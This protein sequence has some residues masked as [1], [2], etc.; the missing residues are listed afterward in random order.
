M[1]GSGDSLRRAEAGTDAA[2]ESPEGD[3]AVSERLGPHAEGIGCPVR[4]LPCFCA[5]DLPSGNA[6]IGAESEPGNKSFFSGELRRIETD[7]RDDRLY[8]EDI[9]AGYLGEVYAAYPVELGAK[10]D[11]GLISDRLLPLFFLLRKG[12]LSRIDLPLNRVQIAFHLPVAGF[13]LP[14]IE[15][16]ELDC[17]F[18]GEEVLG[19]VVSLKSLGDNFGGIL[20][21][22]LSHKGKFLGVPFSGYDCPD[23]V[24]AGDAGHVCEYLMEVKIH[25]SEGFLHVLDMVRGV[26]DKVRPVPP[27][28]PQDAYL[29]VG[30][31]GAG[32]E[33]IG[34]EALEP[35]AV[36][37]VA[38]SSGHV[39]HM[40]GIHELYLESVLFEDLEGRDPVDP[41]RLHGDRSDSAFFQPPRHSVEVGREAAEGPYR[42]LVPV[43]RHSH[44]MFFRTDVDAR[45]I[46]VDDRERTRPSGARPSFFS[47]TVS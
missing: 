17:L 12:I 28:R 16:V 29:I 15:V 24:H 32:E 46:I 23:D 19:P 5:L 27:V 8:G 39:L 47:R 45:S 3:I 21:S 44:P 41:R 25:L 40:A 30:A 14:M 7:F 4:G 38:L 37:D 26:T 43:V 36:G 9:E 10:I 20:H 1:G 22:W 11:K 35:L 33:A 34:V 2:I 18:K 42:V 6:I 13:Y 31:K